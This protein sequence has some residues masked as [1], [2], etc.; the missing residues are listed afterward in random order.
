MG[1]LA[2]VFIIWGLI[3]ALLIEAVKRFLHRPVVDGKIMLIIACVG[4]ACNFINMF[5]LD[6]C[7]A[8]AA[9]DA[10][11]KDHEPN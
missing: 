4:L 3:I 1:A 2:T 9:D 8:Q 11:V 5:I 7:A 6:G 10:K